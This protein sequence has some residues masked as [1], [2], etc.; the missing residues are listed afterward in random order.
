MRSEP[1]ESIN[2]AAGRPRTF[3]SSKKPVTKSVTEIG[4]PT[5]SNVTL[6]TLYPTFF[7]LFYL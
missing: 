4:F 5:S 7:E 6:M 3:W 2:G 1:S